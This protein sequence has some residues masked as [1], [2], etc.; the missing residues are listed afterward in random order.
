MQLFRHTIALDKR[1][2]D[3]SVKRPILIFWLTIAV[4]AIPNIA[5]SITERMPPAATITNVLLPVS[6]VWLLMTLSRRPGKVTW[7]LFLPL[8]VAGFQMVLIYLYGCS[9]IA[10]D[11]Y[12]NLFSANSG[13]AT[14]L[15]GNI[16]P[17]LIAVVIVYLA[18]LVLGTISL[19]KKDLLPSTFI[20]RQ[21]RIALIAVALGVVSIGVSYATD[22]EYRAKLHL[23]PINVGYNLVL[24]VERAHATVNYAKTSEEFTFNAKSTHIADDREIYVLVIGETARV[25]NFSLYGYKRKTTPLL[26]STSGLVT[27]TNVLTQSNTTH[28]SVSLLMSAA[29]AEK[30]DRIYHEKGIVTAFKEAGFHTVFISNQCPN[31][32][33][34][35]FFGE[36]ADE[37]V[38]IKEK[39]SKKANVTDISMLPFLKD[40]L[41]KGRKK[42]LIILHSHGSHFNYCQ[43]YEAAHAVFKPD[44]A[45]AVKWSN[46]ASLINAYDNSIHST[47]SFLHGVIM[48][49]RQ[50]GAQA[51]MLYTSDHGE[52]IF[53]DSRRL[54]LHASP[55]PSYYELHVP[56]IVWMSD[57]YRSTYPSVVATLQNNRHK[58]VSN[59]KS[60]FHTMLEMA[61]IDTPYREDT[62]SVASCKYTPSEW[63]YL[64]DHNKPVPVEKIL[65]SEEDIVKVHN[66]SHHP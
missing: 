48:Q 34:I 5:L 53:D 12:L 13:E 22:R 62:L 20:L 56:F 25:H 39:F 38:F 33:F 26:D 61:G 24:A 7:L 55:V 49:L 3:L 63:M 10:V 59:S 60:T 66:L 1:K 9:I 54:F 15:L 45:S 58:N 8:I 14:E 41:D 46:R 50:S 47:D 17:A 57:P 28:K 32:S 52:N 44:D 43:R 65:R 51:A 11:M 36:A 64:S 2:K 37:W 6:V 29:T 30:Y 21:R 42:E 16:F 4:L 35:D 23:Y 40:V 31:R 18:P 19:C 27:F